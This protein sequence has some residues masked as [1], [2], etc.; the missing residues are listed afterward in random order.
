VGIDPA[1][2][3]S[4]RTPRSV[5]PLLAVVDGAEATAATLERIL[6]DRE[7]RRGGDG[8]LRITVTDLP[9]R[10]QEVASRFLGAEVGEVEA[11][12]L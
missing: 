7:L 9:D 2:Y 8:G 5:Q 1:S 10:F 11:I 12:D 6:D 3:H 4:T